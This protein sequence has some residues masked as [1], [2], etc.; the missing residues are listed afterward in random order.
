MSQ[1][2]SLCIILSVCAGIGLAIICTGIPVYLIFV[3]W[4]SKPKAFDNFMGK[5]NHSCACVFPCVGVG[6]Y[7]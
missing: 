7:V 4:Q 2:M 3:V 5:F 6:G 1:L